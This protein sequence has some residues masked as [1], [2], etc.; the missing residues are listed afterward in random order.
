MPPSS[1]EALSEAFGAAINARDVSGAL[2]LWSEDAAIIQPNGQMLRGRD[3]IGDALRALV[4]NEVSLEIDVTNVFVTAEV[5]IA[6]GTLT[7]RGAGA[8]GRPY[9]QRSQSVVVYGRGSDGGW[10][11]AIDAPWGLPQAREAGGA[12]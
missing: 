2:E 1:P 3:A 8:D 12:A 11:L 9:E 6:V 5:A 10:R 7:M 4:E